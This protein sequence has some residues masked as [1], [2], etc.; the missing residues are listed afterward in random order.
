VDPRT[1]RVLR[2][3][4]PHVVDGGAAASQMC[5]D[6][7]GELGGDDGGWGALG[8]G[9]NWGASVQADDDWGM[10]GGCD[11]WSSGALDSSAL[12]GDDSAGVDAD[13]DA[14]LAARDAQQVPAVKSAASQPRK[15]AK[16][17]DRTEHFG[18]QGSAEAK[19]WPCRALEI[20]CEP[21]AELGVGAHE[22]DLLERYLKS[23]QN[24][25]DAM[26]T[27][28]GD[29]VPPEVAAELSLEEAR[30]HA[31]LEEEA[32]QGT[33][34]GVEEDDED[35]EDDDA[36]AGGPS[37]MWLRRFQRRL[38][39]SPEQVVRY[40]WG[41]EPLWLAPPPQELQGTGDAATPP[42]CG[43]CGASRIFEL[44]LMPML[45]SQ[46]GASSDWGV[47]VVYTC[48]QDCA[49]DGIGLCE[50]YV[51]VQPAV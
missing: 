44:Q 47:V 3:T 46:L 40:A 32:G 35:D 45:A 18:V 21:G 2:S 4:G 50:E 26:A 39:R 34:V 22:H 29:V 49:T 16:K 28:G 19:P 41:G 20:Y 12:A 15:P 23:E 1:W 6:A 36:M 37:G 13:L 30:M 25:E 24:D 42:P 10:A 17:A 14:L 31:E 43:R 7:C 33:S 11:D 5:D 51:V 48:S 27:G 38:E 9:D 8:G